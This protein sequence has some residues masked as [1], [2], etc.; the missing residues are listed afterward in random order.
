MFERLKKFFHVETETFVVQLHVM[1]HEGIISSFSPIEGITSLEEARRR[2]WRLRRDNQWAGEH[3]WPSVTIH[4]D[5]GEWFP[6][7]TSMMVKQPDGTYK[8]WEGR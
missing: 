4:N 6:E 2:A 3:Q 1:S 5:E 8:K 7:I